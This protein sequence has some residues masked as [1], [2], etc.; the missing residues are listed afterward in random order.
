MDRLLS[1]A[2]IVK[3]RGRLLGQVGKTAIRESSTKETVRRA[4][5]TRGDAQGSAK[6]GGGKSLLVCGNINTDR[7]LTTFYRMTVSGRWGTAS[8]GRLGRALPEFTRKEVSRQGSRRW[9]K[10]GK[11]LYSD[12]GREWAWKKELSRLTQLP[13]GRTQAR[14]ARWG[15]GTAVQHLLILWAFKTNE[16]ENI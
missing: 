10:R 12:T 8:R 2:D 9:V 6:P 3:L 1:V 15:Q 5:E 11:T 7:D 13:L 14:V 4:R 16:L